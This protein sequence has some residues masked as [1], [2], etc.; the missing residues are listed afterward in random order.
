MD[1]KTVETYNRGAIEYAKKF[2]GIG[3]RIGCINEVF[4]EYAQPNPRVLEIGCDD[5][6][7]AEE[8]CKKTNHYTGF[9]ISKSFV[10]LAREKLPEVNFQV[11]DVETYEFAEPVDIIFAFASLLHVDKETFRQILKRAHISLSQDGIFYISVK[12]GSYK[13]GEVIKDAFG[14]RTFYFY[15]F[16]DIEEI[17]DGYEII[18]QRKLTV[19]NTPWLYI[20]LKKQRWKK[21]N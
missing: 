12:L 21:D 17:A 19:G 7:D 2:Q 16:G 8:I 1:L 6:R 4:A 13:G 10:A 20:I 5:G 9:D 15:E 14:E 11:A 18:N 3:P